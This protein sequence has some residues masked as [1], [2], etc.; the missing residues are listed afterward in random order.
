MAGATARP[1]RRRGSVE[2]LPSGALRVSVYAGIDA[3][4]GR[5]HYLREVVPA[6]PKAAS[7][8]EKVARRL[9][10]QV[11]E[12]RNPRTA[13]TVDQL[14]DK[15]LETLDVGVTTHR[16]YTKYLTKHV[17]PFIGRTKAGALDAD[18]LDSLY[19][20]LRRCQIHCR[21][22]GLVDH[23]TPRP[24]SCDERCRPHQ[25][26]PLSASTIRQ[27]HFVLRG[28]FAKA[29][30]W[31]WVSINPVEFASPPGAKTPEPQPPSAEEAARIV[32]EAWRDPDWG[33]LV[34][35]TMTTGARRGE[36][37]AIRWSD[38]DL[39]E[40]VLNLRRSIRQDE[41]RTVEK[42]TKTHQHRRLTLDPETVALLGEHRARA[43]ERCTELGIELNR[44][45]FVFSRDPAGKSHLLPGSVTQRFSRMT[46]RLGIDSHLH[47]LRHYSAT[48]LIAAG[49]DIRTVAGRLGHSGGGVT[50]LRVYAAWLAEADQRASTKLA[51]RIPVRPPATDALPRAMTNPRT[52]REVLAAE[53]RDMVVA[54]G[55]GVGDHLPSIK[56]LAAERDLSVSTVHR[57]FELLRE[58]GV[59]AGPPGERP[60]VLA[61]P[62]PVAVG[63][64]ASGP[65]LDS[66]ESPTAE[67]DEAADGELVELEV[68]RR[69]EVVARLS[70]IADPRDGGELRE[71]L[72]GVVER[73][74]GAESDL[75]QY[76]MDV[77]RPGGEVILTFVAA[78]RRRR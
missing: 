29:Q 58:W 46:A 12:R 50:T 33:M 54:G 42:D 27:I 74:G 56:A 68:R 77:R 24:H 72:L 14:L 31:R 17:R 34:W 18:A 10:A 65:G 57:A 25:C 73:A 39:D 3:V 59:V 37:C 62:V 43:E 61:I 51:A 47:C 66:P 38:L 19:A 2:E 30:R 64:S 7:E 5:R 78:R 49:V 53:L 20:E 44:R 60:T 1:K 22:R 4:T 36:L 52:P 6:G 70:T 76:E 71:L 21:T 23:R 45:A 16:T 48:E 69:G 13:T 8:A 28:A 32:D 67:G 63:E 40:G 11:D 35:L 55:I 9:A 41:T 15:Y 26:L 75:G